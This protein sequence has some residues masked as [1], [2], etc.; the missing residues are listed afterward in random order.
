MRATVASHVSV[1][2]RRQNIL[3][4][5]IDDATTPESNRKADGFI[6]ALRSAS[7][8]G[9]DCLTGSFCPV[10][11]KRGAGHG[12]RPLIVLTLLRRVFSDSRLGRPRRLRV[13]L[14]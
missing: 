3:I 7:Q 1:T 2:P 6:D 10:E 8:T 5:R 4:L 13:R 11:E 14:R 9:V 12:H